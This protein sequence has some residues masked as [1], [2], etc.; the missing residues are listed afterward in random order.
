MS[1]IKKYNNGDTE[2]NKFRYKPTMVQ[3]APPLVTKRI[4]TGENPIP[5]ENNEFTRRADDLSRISQLF[6]RRE[7]V[8]FTSN[9]FQLGTAVDLSYTVQGSACAQ[10]N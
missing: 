7:G 2:L 4:P 8:K 10:T 3:G 5:V 6:G 1:I 9:N